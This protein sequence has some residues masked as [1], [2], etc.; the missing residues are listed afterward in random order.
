MSR[1]VLSVFLALLVLSGLS[2][3][4]KADVTGSFGIHVTLYGEGIT[5]LGRAQTE[6]VKLNIDLQTNLQVNVTL[7]GLTLS[8]DLGFG[9]TGVEF[10]ILGLTTNLGALAIHDDFVFAPPFGCT[11]FTPSGNATLLDD[12]DNFSGQCPG[13]N[14]VP[15]GDGDGD[16][17]VDNAVGFVKKRI[18]MELN[19]AGITL[20]NW[21]LFE[22]VDF[23]DINGSDSHEHD[24]SAGAP[25]VYYVG[26]NNSVVDDQTPTYG[27]GDVINLTGQTVSGITITSGTKLCASGT[28][29][30]KK[31][32]WPFEVNKACTASLGNILDPAIEDGAKT[33]LLFEEEL[34]GIE[35][36][37]IGGVT[38]DTY[39]AWRPNQV[40]GLTTEIEASFS[41][42][43]LADVVVTM[44][45]N[46]ITALS[47]DEID[48][49]VSSGNLTLVMIDFGGDL[50]IDFTEVVLAVVLNPNQN[51]ADLVI[52]I[53]AEAG[54]GITSASFSLGV[55]RGPLSFDTT[56]VFA[57]AGA[58]EW[59]STS[60]SLSVDTG[61]G[62]SFGAE[63]E[64]TP[65][66]MGDLNIQLGV[67]F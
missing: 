22:D 47:L 48:V 35:G 65:N 12:A 36:L 60:F 1:S 24:H 8:A 7:S 56:T 49:V 32:S 23:P 21:A 19:I 14:V 6:S 38:I 2:V 34:L 53:V 11:L 58:L 3:L 15:I 43:D 51:P 67:V 16:G 45:S 63:F 29:T 57:G 26:Q 50:S 30:I 42:L 5:V 52:D 31:R 44:T 55:S 25:K 27:F 62:I 40:N 18:K 13:F 37:E 46:N 64:Y 54:A 28:N 10:A 66:G 59:E 41:L 4:S 33:P 20:T 61:S 39:T 9:T 17:V